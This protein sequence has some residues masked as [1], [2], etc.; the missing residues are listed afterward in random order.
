MPSD[1]IIPVLRERVASLETWRDEH[2][3]QH[4][5]ELQKG[6][7]STTR[8]TMIIVGLIGLVGAIIG[9]IVVSIVSHLLLG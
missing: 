5:Q 3:H 4:D 9:G 8:R 2:K 7:G 1:S 6:E